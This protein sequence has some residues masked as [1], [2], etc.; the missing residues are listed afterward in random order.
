MS[1]GPPHRRSPQVNQLRASLGIRPQPLPAAG[2]VGGTLHITGP[3]EKPVFSGA[4][5]LPIRAAPARHRSAPAQHRPAPGTALLCS[6]LPA[7]ARSSAVRSGLAAGAAQA[8]G[9]CLVA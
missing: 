5:Q 1:S 8:K 9:A 7:S 6:A 2:A 4:R 3:L